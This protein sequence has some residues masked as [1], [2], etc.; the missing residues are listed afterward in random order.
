MSTNYYIQGDVC[1]HCNHRPDNLH[2]GKSSIGWMFSL[3]VYPEQGINNIFD[4]LPRLKQDTIVDEYGK[5]LSFEQMV[6]IIARRRPHTQNVN[7]LQRHEIDGRH[8][9]GHGE[10][11]YDYIVGEFC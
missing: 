10:G 4:W 11:T 1:P 7:P 5:T 3:R 6:D 2:I 8:C 9:V